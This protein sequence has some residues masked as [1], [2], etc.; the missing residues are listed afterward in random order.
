V[1]GGTNYRF[2]VMARNYRA[3]GFPGAKL[4]SS[5]GG[6][7]RI[8]VTITPSVAYIDEGKPVTFNIAVK[9]AAVGTTFYWL[10]RPIPMSN[11][12]IEWDGDWYGQYTWGD[13]NPFTATVKFK[14]D[15]KIEGT[16]T[17]TLHVYPQFPVYGMYW[18][19]YATANIYV[20]DAAPKYEFRSGAPTSVNEGSSIT[21]NVDTAYV[22]NGTPIYW[23]VVNFTTNTADFPDIYGNFNINNNTGSFSIPVKADT[24]TEGDQEFYVVLRRFG[25]GSIGSIPLAQSKLVT[26]IDTSTA[27]VT[28]PPVTPPPVTPPPVTPPVTP[29]GCVIE[30]FKPIGANGVITNGVASVTGKATGG[31]VY[32]NASGYTTDSDFGVAAVH[33]GI[34]TAGQTGN[35]RFTNLGRL[36]SFLSSTANGITTFSWSVAHCAVSISA[37]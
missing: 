17:F 20:S 8:A 11:E 18:H 14:E 16:K 3:F 34:L 7:N 10:L 31:G 36:P 15:N 2:D 33:A 23:D 24:S 26:I 27:P 13:S 37:G 1:N 30:G 22:A 12:D 25:N 9:N 4:Y 28:P 19:E 5:I 6:V 21:F 29:D 35:I 32:G